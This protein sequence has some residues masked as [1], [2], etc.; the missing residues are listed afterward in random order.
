MTNTKPK[1]IFLSPPHM[2]GEELAECEKRGKLPKA[3]IPTDLYGNVADYERIFEISETKNVI[4]SLNSA[5]SIL[6]S[7]AWQGAISRI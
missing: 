5:I 2:G 1:R 3:V 4:V 6:S 7:L